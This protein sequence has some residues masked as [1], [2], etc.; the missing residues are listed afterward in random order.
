MIF[1]QTKLPGVFEIDLEPKHDDRGFFARCWCQEEF[2]SS[3]LNSKL[4]QCNVS[5][6]RTEGN[7]P[8]HA[9]PGG[10]LRRGEAGALHS[11][12]IVRRGARSAPGDADL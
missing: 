10:S 2:E 6:N 7:T 8:G 12:G 1:R 5:F 9:L 3:G 11:R 4:V